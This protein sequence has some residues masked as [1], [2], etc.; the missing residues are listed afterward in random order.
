MNFSPDY[1]FWV[2]RGFFHSLSDFKDLLSI[3]NAHFDG[4]PAQVISRQDLLVN[5]R[6]VGR[7]QDLLDVNSLVESDRALEKLSRAPKPKKNKPKG[8]NRETER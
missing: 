6:A 7:P 2:G 5:K 8:R 4:I 1:Y 3:L